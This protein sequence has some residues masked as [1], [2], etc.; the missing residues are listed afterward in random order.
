MNLWL[1]A[2]A[3]L[4]CGTLSFAADQAAKG[5]LDF[6]MNDIDGKPVELSKYK[7]Q[8][9]LI[10]NVAS[11]CGH[12]PQYT[13]LEALYRKHKD[14]GFTILAFPANNFLGQ[15]PGTNAQIKEFCTAANSKYHVTFPLFAKIS[16]KGKDGHPLYQELTK[17][18]DENVKAGDVSWN[19]EKFLIG[20]DGKVIA[21]FAPKTKPDDA[22]I[23]GAVEKALEK[24]VK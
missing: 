8:V 20:R 13:A 5:P 12:T 24:Q 18:G 10:V 21:R 16:V 2:A 19:F 23:T 14:K 11:K 22:K 7:G 1:A 3:V 6:T 17:F 15:E 4:A 9:V